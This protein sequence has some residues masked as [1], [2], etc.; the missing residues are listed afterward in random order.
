MDPG[1]AAWLLDPGGNPPTLN[2]L[3][4]VSVIIGMPLA[5]GA[6]DLGVAAW[7]WTLEGILPH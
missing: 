1:V 6:V 4:T 5:G 3:I 2:P 7:S